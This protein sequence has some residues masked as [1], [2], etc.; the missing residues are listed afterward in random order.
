[1]ICVTY[2]RAT[3]INNDGRKNVGELKNGRLN[4]KASLNNQTFT[5]MLERSKNA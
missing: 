1:M 3:L 2:K 5:N 4:G